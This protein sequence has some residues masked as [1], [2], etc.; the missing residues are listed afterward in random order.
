MNIADFVG[1]KARI[2]RDYQIVKP[3]F[4]FLVT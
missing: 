2:G 1:G 3:K 4:G